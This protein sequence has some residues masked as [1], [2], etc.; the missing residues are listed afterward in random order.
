MD[1]ISTI[2]LNTL[3][4]AAL[5]TLVTMSIGTALSYVLA[6][7]QFFGKN[8]L[9]TILSLPL[10]L[11]PTAVGFLLL[12]LLADDGLLGLETIGFDLSLLLNW[13]GIILACSV[14][15]LPLVIRTARVSFEAVDP[16]LEVIAETLGM[17]Q[18][19]IF[20]RITLPLASRGLLA[21]AVLGFTRA[22]GEF[23]ATV[24]VAGNIPGRTQ[25]LSSAIYSA[26]QSG[27]DARANTL[28][29]VAIAVGFSA[30]FLTEWLTRPTSPQTEKRAAR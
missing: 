4:W 15:S 5:S 13:K 29:I 7:Y 24:I 28:L 20:F 17:N 16:K 27:N 14:M 11:P 1:N 26:Q 12:Q 22:M 6:R 19:Q 18:W 30:I 9:S 8:V 2:V 25:T 10:V 23:G 3:Y 21:A